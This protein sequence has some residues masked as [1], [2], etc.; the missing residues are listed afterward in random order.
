MNNRI[1]TLVLAIVAAGTAAFG[2]IDGPV[3]YETCELNDGTILNGFTVTTLED[4]RTVFNTENALRILSPEEAEKRIEIKDNNPRRG[5]ADF[6]GAWIRL[7][8]CYPDAAASLLNPL[9]LPNIRV[10]FAYTDSI[11]DPLG[12]EVAVVGRDDAGNYRVVSV[13]TV[14]DT[15]PT[16]NIRV[17]RTKPLAPNAKVG[18]LDI[19]TLNDGEE[20]EGS[21]I[22]DYP[23]RKVTVLTTDGVLRDIGVNDYKVKEIAAVNEELPVV[24][25]S[26]FHSEFFFRDGSKYSGVIGALDYEKNVIVIVEDKGTVKEFPFA[27]YKYRTTTR[28]EQ[29]P[30]K[31]VAPLRY[32]EGQMYANG[33]L[34][35]PVEKKK[36]KF[37]IKSEEI[38]A[39]DFTDVNGSKGLK[40]TYREPAADR[41]TSMSFGNAVL[42]RA[43][44]PKRSFDSKGYYFEVD[45]GEAMGTGIAPDRK[46]RSEK[47]PDI[48][49]LT[50]SDIPNGSYFLVFGKNK[51]VFFINVTS[52]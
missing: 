48:V 1:L 19:Y 3:V 24:A 5:F 32:D 17:I 20:V 29:Y 4:G 37:E 38:E 31:P 7:R 51:N 23:G 50:F 2:A 35:R 9:G 46:G 8:E 27:D 22:A 28:N 25:Q 13:R 26:P 41:G 30:P 45:R 10:Q 33:K 18:I 52:E 16:E 21:L 49:E 42:V 6:D 44:N 36:D 47:D 14:R 11:G 43:I 34:I 12:S 40:I 15:I 39:L